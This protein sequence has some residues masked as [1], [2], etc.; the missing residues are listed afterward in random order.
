[1]HVFLPMIELLKKNKFSFLIIFLIFIF[2]ITFINKYPHSIFHPTSDTYEYAD[3]AR[4]LLKYKKFVVHNVYSLQLAFDFA[5][6]IPPPSIVRVPMYPITISFFFKIFGISDRTIFLTSFTFYILSGILLVIFLDKFNIDEK[7]KNLTLLFFMFNPIFLDLTLRGLSE[8]FAL[9]IFILFLF[10]LFHGKK[11][12]SIFISGFF[13]GIFTLTRYY[14]SLFFLIPVFYYFYK[15]GKTQK[16]IVLFLL[17]VFLPLLPWFFRMYRITG[18]PFFSLAFYSLDGYERVNIP[19]IT[20]SSEI[21]SNFLEFIDKKLD[22][23]M[24][25]LKTLSNIV[26]F[27]FLPFSL[28]YVFSKKDEDLEVLSKF[29]FISLIVFS[30]LYGIINPEHRFLFYLSFFVILF[31]LIFIREY[32]KFFNFFIVFTLLLVVHEDRKIIKEAMERNNNYFKSEKVF[33]E[34]K[35]I[36]KENEFLITNSDALLGFYTERS[37]IFPL[38][39]KEDYRYLFK[40]VP[41]QGFF[42]YRGRFKLF[43]MKYDF[44]DI[45]NMVETEFPFKKKFEDGSLIYLKK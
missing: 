6:E 23:L 12:K 20:S 26:P 38:T 21:F 8:P 16:E 10:F 9:F 27:Y 2:G 36:T 33:E 29:F 4:N 32:Q 13:L 11:N 44:G 1:V 43:Y 30:I 22:S 19:Y 45:K 28:I 3:I 17:G 5:R 25:Y 7:I 35:R 34:V 14:L 42:V 24:F 18:I 31:S 15:K 39:Y 40:I 41:V 37:C